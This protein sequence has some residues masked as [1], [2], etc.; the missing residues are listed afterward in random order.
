MRE[1][2]KITALACGLLSDELDD[3]RQFLFNLSN[4][5][6][7]IAE[8]M[9]VIREIEESGS[10]S[11]LAKRL[12]RTIDIIDDEALMIQHTQDPGNPDGLTNGF[13]IRTIGDSGMCAIKW[14]GDSAMDWK[15]YGR[16][17]K[18]FQELKTDAEDEMV[19]LY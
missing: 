5:G 15:Y 9:D 7:K 10:F 14:G 13:F 11:E 8:I 19:V 12:G 3:L 4:S 17:E 16:L 2:I 1:Q 6:Y 18:M